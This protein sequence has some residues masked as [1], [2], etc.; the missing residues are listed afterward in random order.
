MLPRLD[1]TPL[2]LWGEGHKPNEAL[3]NWGR[4]EDLL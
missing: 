1:S 2:Y 4:I 3:G